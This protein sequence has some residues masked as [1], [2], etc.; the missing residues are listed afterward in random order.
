MSESKPIKVESTTTTSSNPTQKRGNRNRRIFIPRAPKFTGRTE[1]IKNDIF[2]VPDGRNPEQFSKTL[3]SIADYILKEYKNGIACSQS[4][5]DMMTAIIQ[6]PDTPD[7]FSDPVKI[8]IFNEEVREYVKEKKMF[9]GQLNSAYGLI[10]GQCTPGM[11]CAIESHRDYESFK[12]VGDPIALLKA[13]QEISHGC[14]SHRYLPLQLYEAKKRLFLI[15]QRRGQSLQEYHKGFQAQLEVIQG[16]GGSFDGKDLVNWALKKNDIDPPTASNIQHA[17]AVQTSSEAFEAIAF[18]SGADKHR[19]GRM[20]DDL[21]NDQMKNVDSF[22]KTLMEAYNFLSRWKDTTY[23]H[24]RIDA[25]NDGINFTTKGNKSTNED[26]MT[27]SLQEE[28]VLAIK[29]KPPT[30]VKDKPI[31]CYKC[32]EGG[33]IAPNCPHNPKQPKNDDASDTEER[34]ISANQLLTQGINDNFDEYAFNLHGITEKHGEVNST[35]ALQH[36]ISQDWILLDN[37]STVDVFVNPKLVKNIQSTDNIMHIHSHSG[38]S[39]TRFQATLPG[40]GMVWFD[41][42]GIA[43]ILSLSNIKKKYRVTFDSHTDDI[44]PRT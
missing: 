17:R 34:S 27:S 36:T 43:N 20:F 23:R 9:K 41:P 38:V 22:P 16:L 3:E 4:I 12:K 21:E 2:D 30:K 26:H 31:K 13:I 33:H 44:F 29:G 15:T 10:L 39:S 32:G 8:A 40:Y 7:D 18:L 35:A 42:N 24:T 11:K 1:E 6:E 5:R 25:S 14:E 19:Y 37:Q 28:T